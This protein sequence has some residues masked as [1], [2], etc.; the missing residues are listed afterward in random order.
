MINLTNMP[1]F[2]IQE[3]IIIEVVEQMMK[4]ERKPKIQ[5]MIRL[6]G[7]NHIDEHHLASGVQKLTVGVD[8]DEGV[9][10]SAPEVLA[11]YAYLLRM[12]LSAR[13]E[14]YGDG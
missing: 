2:G 13:K 1:K 3:Q 5:R 7:V 8:D 12:E 6:Y 11:L 9:V 14:L 10:L 4:D